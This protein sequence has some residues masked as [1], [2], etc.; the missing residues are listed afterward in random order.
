MASFRHRA[1]LRLKRSWILSR[2]LTRCAA[3]CSTAADRLRLHIMRRRPSHLFPK[4]CLQNKIR[5]LLNFLVAI[6]WRTVLNDILS[7]LMMLLV[8]FCH[9]IFRC[10]YILLS[11]HCPRCSKILGSSFRTSFAPCIVVYMFD[12]TLSN[13]VYRFPNMLLSRNLFWDVL[14]NVKA[15]GKRGK[16][17]NFR[18]LLLDVT[19]RTRHQ[20]G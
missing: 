1:V 2:R 13:S 16:A 8:I 4:Q 10:K 17:I 15:K 18:C 14:E 12:R 19:L 6:S 5:V 7:L 11:V 9:A 20:V 3:T